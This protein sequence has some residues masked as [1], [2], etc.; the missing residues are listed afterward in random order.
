MHMQ[1]EFT[2]VVCSQVLKFHNYNVCITVLSSSVFY[3]GVRGRSVRQ[4]DVSER[5]HFPRKF[6]PTGQ[7]ILSASRIICP[8]L[9]GKSVHQE[10]VSGLDPII[11]IAL[12]QLLVRARLPEP[13]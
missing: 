1:V 11:D 4:A 2:L 13:N 7:S 12:L 5:T 3:P 6:C 8:G 9:G 10:N